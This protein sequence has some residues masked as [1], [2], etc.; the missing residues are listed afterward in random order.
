MNHEVQ[1][2]PYYTITI[3][4]DKTN[5]YKRRGAGVMVFKENSLLKHMDIRVCPKER[6]FE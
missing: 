1:G 2:E 4:L 3:Y 6:F 5:I